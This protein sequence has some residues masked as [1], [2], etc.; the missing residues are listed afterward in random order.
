MERL[1]YIHYNDNQCNYV[2]EWSK[3]RNKQE[4]WWDGIIMAQ[5]FT[6]PFLEAMSDTIL[7]PGFP[8]NC[9]RLS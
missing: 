5:V 3:A 2:Q 4:F 1:M 7:T 9:V 6:S 8:R